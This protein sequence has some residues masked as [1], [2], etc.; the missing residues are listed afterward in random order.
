M[1]TGMLA[2]WCRTTA[3]ENIV[4]AIVLH[5]QVC[6]A[7]SPPCKTA[8]CPNHAEQQIMHAHAQTSQSGAWH[9][10]LGLYVYVKTASTGNCSKLT[11]QNEVWASI[12]DN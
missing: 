8:P 2:L 3:S 7:S 4:H 11:L 1:C 6:Q 9:V 12:C 10:I 5:T